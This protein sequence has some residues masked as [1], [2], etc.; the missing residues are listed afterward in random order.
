[1]ISKA[2]YF[3]GF[4]GGGTKTE[5]VLLDGDGSVVSQAVTG[6]S[7]PLRAGFDKAI[8]SLNEAADRVLSAARTDASQI[9]A[10]CA[11]MAGAGRGRV[12]KRMM[13]AL[14]Q[15]FPRSDVSVTTDMEVALEAAVGE[16][17]GV[18]LIAGTGSAAFGR[19]ADGKMARAGGLGP[20]IGDEGS[21]YD[22]GRRAVMVV[23]KA[24]DLMGP[25]TLLAE[26]IPSALECAN[27]D[28]LTDRIAKSPDEVFPRIFPLVVE[29]AEAEDDPAR[30]IL[31]GAAIGLA[32]LAAAV[33]RR[34][35]LEDEE[36]VVAKS[37]GVFGRSAFFDQAVEA[38][39]TSAARRARVEPLRVAPAIG[40]GRMAMRLARAHSPRAEHAVRR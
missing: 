6:P 28:A 16:G 15:R 35:G 32:A 9:A 2:N 36:F 19:R 24:R 29:A 8:H 40:A 27:W 21:A 7:N 31:F 1:M 37:G 13:A 20:W 14:A 39:V 38:L 34:L 17:Q 33:V 5:C 26:M 25:V 22:I 18:V 30:E 12:V 11:G 10:V 23:A 4:D 3:I